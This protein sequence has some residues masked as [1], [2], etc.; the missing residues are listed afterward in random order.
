[1]PDFKKILQFIFI[2]I[3]AIIGFK[4]LF[5]FTKLAFVI[6]K[7]LFMFAV[8]ASFF[9]FIAKYFFKKN[10]VRIYVKEEEKDK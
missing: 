1:M 2:F 10:G 7:F 3:F 4:L 9:Y 5:I 8:I 6:I